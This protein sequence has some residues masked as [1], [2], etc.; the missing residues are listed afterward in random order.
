MHARSWPVPLRVL[1]FCLLA[2]SQAWATGRRTRQGTV[3]VAGGAPPVLYVAARLS[4]LVDFEELLEPAALLTPELRARVGVVPV[5]PRSLVL[6]PLRD[7]AEG[8]RLLVPVT[9][10]TEAGEPRTLTLAL[11]TRRDEVD[12][13]A[14]V[15]FGSREPQPMEASA[16]PVGAVAEM[17]L[18]SHG[19]GAQPRLALVTPGETWVSRQSDGLRARVDSVFRMDQRLFVTVSVGTIQVNSMP[20]RLVRARMESGCEAS[21]VG[22]ES[23]LPLAVTP[24]A[25]EGPWQRYVFSTRI[26]AGVGCMALTME[27]D[28]PRVLRFEHVRSLP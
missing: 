10:R 12:L 24:A 20:W 8:E 13:Q 5:G 11:V 18:A 25:A 28:G 7:L 21:R 26:P 27:E 6:V 15:S 19:P 4:T 2:A 1:F 22:V 23:A 3:L 9:G 16:D 14:R 17:L